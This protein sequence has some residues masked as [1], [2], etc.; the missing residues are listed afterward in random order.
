MPSRMRRARLRATPLFRRLRPGPSWAVL[1]VLAAL[2]AAPLAARAGTPLTPTARDLLGQYGQA[3]PKPFTAERG[4]ALYLSKHRAADGKMRSCSLCHT[5][6]PRHQ[7]R[8]DV[9]KPIDPLAPAANPK[10]FTNADDVEKWF[11]R[12]CR[13]TLGRTCTAQEK[14]DFIT[15]L[16]SLP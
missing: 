1:T 14:G 3:A 5:D 4:R 2:L 8:S 13:W 10:R 6:D 15:Y 9:G 16:F 11:R 12:N 7:G